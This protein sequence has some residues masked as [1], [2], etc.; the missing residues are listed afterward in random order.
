MRAHEHVRAGL[1]GDG[2][3][4]MLQDVEGGRERRSRRS[5]GHRPPRRR[6]RDRRAR[7]PRDGRARPRLGAGPWA[8]RVATWHPP[9][10]EP[11]ARPRRAPGPAHGRPARRRRGRRRP[12]RGVRGADPRHRPGRLAGDRPR[13]R[14]R[15]CGAAA[16]RHD[17]AGTTRTSARRAPRDL[18]PDHVLRADPPASP[19]RRSRTSPTSRRWGTPSTSCSSPATTCRTTPAEGAGRKEPN[20]ILRRGTANTVDELVSAAEYVLIRGQP[21]RDPLRQGIRTSSGCTS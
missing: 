20:G 11:R 5:T 12:L 10:H 9:R 1:V 6:A 16:Q 15:R 8:A 18:D 4:S 2:R 14:R 3:P 17:V 19:Q 13:V 7:Q 21:E